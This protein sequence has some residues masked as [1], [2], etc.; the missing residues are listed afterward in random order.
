MLLSWHYTQVETQ[1]VH[2]DSLMYFDLFMTSTFSFV[3]IP[4][5]PRED[6]AERANPP[7]IGSFQRKLFEV[8]FWLCVILL[9]HFKEDTSLVS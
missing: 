1:S 8:Y 9:G 7:Y 3:V 2:V 5:Q 6:E 4:L